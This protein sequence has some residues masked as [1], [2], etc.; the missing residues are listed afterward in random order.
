[1]DRG[2]KEERFLQVVG[3][4]ERRK[5]RATKAPAMTIWRGLGQI[6][7][8]GWSVVTPALVGAGGG[9]LLE[10]ELGFR[11]GWALWL[12]SIGLVFGCVA[13]YRWIR[14]EYDEIDEDG[15]EE[16]HD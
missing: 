9:W 16:H 6:G 4:K 2:L 13:A 3:E 10:K 8:V 5:L 12:F 14:K 1:M 15:E 11:C 7:M